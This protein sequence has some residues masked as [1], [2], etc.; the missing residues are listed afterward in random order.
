MPTDHYA[1][2]AMQLD[3]Q[4]YT[5]VNEGDY[6]ARRYEEGDFGKAA[7][8]VNLYHMG[9]YFAEVFYDYDLN[10]I[11]STRTFTNAKCLEDYAAYIKLTD[12][13]LG[14]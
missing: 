3:E 9:T 14:S 11:V 12:L 4:I 10:K 8:G 7:N 1:F 6:F 5:V 13:D 2:R